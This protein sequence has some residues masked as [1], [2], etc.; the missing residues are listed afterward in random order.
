MLKRRCKS[1][2]FLQNEESC[3]VLSGKGQSETTQKASII[4]GIQCPTCRE[5]YIGKT[6]RFFV[7]ILVH[8]IRY[9]QAMFQYLIFVNSLEKS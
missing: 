3:N 5:H 7:T 8:G 1:Y 2:Q 6:E 9:D 4:Y